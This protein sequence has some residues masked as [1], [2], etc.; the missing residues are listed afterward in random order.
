MRDI[1]LISLDS[2]SW[3]LHQYSRRKM[4]ANENPEV[5]TRSQESNSGTYDC[6]ADALPHDH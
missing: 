4:R 6:E 1:I 5:D 2:A 3:K